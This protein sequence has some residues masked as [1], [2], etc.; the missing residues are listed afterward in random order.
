MPFSA[1]DKH[2][3]DGGQFEHKMWTF[4][5]YDI[6]YRN[7]QTQLFEILLF[8]SVIKERPAVADKP[9]RRLRKVCMVYVK[10]VGL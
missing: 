3:T 8:C 9:A 2:A 6:L 10:A 1:E 5:I 7:F 4:V